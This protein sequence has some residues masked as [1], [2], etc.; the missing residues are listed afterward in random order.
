MY[1]VQCFGDSTKWGNQTSLTTEEFGAATQVSLRG[2]A[3][4]ELITHSEWEESNE[5]NED[6]ET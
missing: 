1:E 4:R 2:S 6:H 3:R 5:S